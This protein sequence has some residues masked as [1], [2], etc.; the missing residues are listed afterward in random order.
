[1]NKIRVAVVDDDENIHQ[2]IEKFFNQFEMIY[3]FDFNVNYFL[4][5][6]EIYDK[7]ASENEYDL[8]FLDIE[9][10]KMKGTDLGNTLRKKLK[11]HDTQVVFIS[12]IKEYAMDLFPTHP[13]DFIIKPITYDRF[14]SF[15]LTYMTHYENSNGF[16]EY[17]MENIKHRIRVREV[18]YLESHGKKVEFHTRKGEFLVYG[19]ISDI[20][21]DYMDKFICISRGIY[22]NIHHI[23]EA[24]PQEILLDNNCS[25]YISRSCR[26]VVRDRLSEI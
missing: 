8:I 4:S 1:M 12:A 7:L 13:I 3:D 26:N 21:E 5:C 18:Y 14:S 6:E 10:P 19:K 25:L 24:T 23:I 20:I 15:M 16:L 22:V 9:F 2:E 11:N 17:N